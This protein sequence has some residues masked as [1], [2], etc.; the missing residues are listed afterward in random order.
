MALLIALAFVGAASGAARPNANPS[1]VPAIV[2]LNDGNP[3]ETALALLDPTTL[4]Q[5]GRTVPLGKMSFGEP[6]FST[7]SPSRGRL[8]LATFVQIGVVDLRRRRLVGTFSGRFFG[9]P[10]WPLA[11]RLIGLDLSRDVDQVVV[12][13]PDRRS[14]IARRDIPDHTTLQAAATPRELV[15]MKDTGLG[16]R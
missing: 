15:V 3:S 8:A 9:A 13:D 10:A 16:S 2:A 1:P 6:V 14:V 11:N 12:I 7:R 5:V 4:R